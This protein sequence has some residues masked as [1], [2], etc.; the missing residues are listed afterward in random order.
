VTSVSS[1]LQKYKLKHGTDISAEGLADMAN[2]VVALA[3]GDDIAT[4]TE[5]TAH[6]V[7]E[8]FSDRQAIEDVLPDVVS[9][10]EY[11]ANAE[12]YRAIYARQYRDEAQVENLVRREILGK[13][14]AKEYTSRMEA[15][16]RTLLQKIRALINRFIQ[17]LRGTHT[18]QSD[19]L[20][21]VIRQLA[22][23]SLT[24][25]MTRFDSNH[26]LDNDFVMYNAPQAKKDINTAKYLEG[27]D[28]A[29]AM[30]NR[31]KIET[32]AMKAERER[33][34]EKF[35]EGEILN[36]LSMFVTTVDAQATS[37]MQQMK[38]AKQQQ[39]SDP[40]KGWWQ[41][42]S[43]VQLESVRHTLL[44][45]MN[46]LRAEVN[47]DTYGGAAEE[48]ATLLK[49][50]DE[51]VR[52]TNEVASE[53]KRLNRMDSASLI[54]R[55]CE[56]YGVPERSRE[57]IRKHVGDTVKD[58]MAITRWFGALEHSSNPVLG[59]LMNVISEANTK[60][61]IHARTVM[62]PLFK[63]IDEK[64]VGNSQYRQIITRDEKGNPTGYLQ[65]E[66]DFARYSRARRD[67]QLLALQ[68]VVR[69]ENGNLKYEKLSLDELHKLSRRPDFA[70]GALR[71]ASGE[72]NRMSLT[73]DE[74]AAVKTYMDRWDEENNE[75]PYTPE[76]YARQE[77][78]YREMAE[79]REDYIVYD[80]FGNEIYAIRKGEAISVEARRVVKNLSGRRS[81][82]L[83]KYRD[84]NGRVDWSR[85][86]DDAA[87]VAALNQI[88]HD[89]E[90][91]KSEYDVS[92][93]E[94]K[95]GADLRIAKDIQAMDNY[96][97]DAA[98]QMKA[99][100]ALSDVTKMERKG[101]RMHVTLRNG[102]RYTL[103][104]PRRRMREEFFTKVREIQLSQGNQT[105]YDFVRKNG[106]LTFGDAF[107]EQ[108]AG[109]DADG[110][111]RFRRTV[112]D[113]LS[114][115]D[116]FLDSAEMDRIMRMMAR[117][118]EVRRKR[119]EVLRAHR[120]FDNP[121]ETD[122]DSMSTDARDAVRRYTEEL[123]ELREDV[124]AVFGSQEITLE[125]SEF[126]ENEANEAYY[127]AFADDSTVANE[128][129]F[130]DA[131]LT[132]KGQSY[133][134]HFRRQMERKNYL[135]EQREARFI[136]KY[137]S[138]TTYRLKDGTPDTAG[139]LDEYFSAH[140]S[141]D[142]LITEY[143][144]T[145]LLPYFKR[146]APAG[147]DALLRDMR[148]GRV[149]M[150]VMLSELRQP[151]EQRNERY[152]ML[153]LQTQSDWYEDDDR[154]EQY[155]NSDYDW[156]GESGMYQPRLSKYRNEDFFS[157][158]APVKD[159]NG[160]WRASQ[161]RELWDMIE[162]FKGIKR[163]ALANYNEQDR[164]FH[165]LYQL[166][167]ISKTMTQKSLDALSAAG[168]GKGKGA[169]KQMTN[170]LKDLL[171]TR[172]D[173]PLYGQGADLRNVETPGDE[174]LLIMPKYYL[175][176]LEDASD[177]ST[178]LSYAY[179]MLIY[180]SARYSANMDAIGEVHGL[181]QELLDLKFRGKAATDTNMYKMFKD[182]ANYHFY[183]RRMNRKI[184][185]NVLGH[186]VDASKAVHLFTRLTGVA[187]L[188]YSLVIGGTSAAT[189]ASNIALERVV[190]Q[191]V[192][193][194]SFKRALNETRKMAPDFFGEYA[195]RHKKS[196]L[197]VLGE[198]FGLY[199]FTERA[200]NSGYRKG[201]R[202]FF[203]A[204]NPF[205]FMEF[206]NSPFTP[207]VMTSVLMGYRLVDG[208]FMNFNQFER[209]E[210]FAGMS[211]KEISAEWSK[212]KDW[213]LW[214]GIEVNDGLV[215][216]AGR[217]TDP[218]RGGVS[219][220]VMDAAVYRAT[221]EIQVLNEKCDGTIAAED[222][223]TIARNY[224]TS[225]I[226]MHQ[227]WLSQAIARRRKP[228]GYNFSTNQEEEGAY[229]TMIRFFR[230]AFGSVEERNL[231]G[232][233]KALR[234][235]WKNLDKVD[236]Q[237]WKRIYSDAAA[238][239]AF[240]AIAFILKGLS[241]DDDNKDSWIVQLMAYVGLRTVNEMNSQTFE[242]VFFKNVV[243][244]VKSPLVPM[245]Q[246]QELIA[247]KDYFGEVEQGR[248]K[249]HLKL[250]RKITELTFWKNI[251]RILGAESIRKSR[252][253][254]ENMAA[255]YLWIP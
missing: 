179:S 247:L 59:M 186:E 191:Y 28:A 234:A 178:D 43:E 184:A 202:G 175:G 245:R 5:E 11:K 165:N 93:G 107:W 20:R 8:T 123:E 251:D 244:R 42:K 3:N 192:D 137:F 239:A 151:A 18:D 153:E 130:I 235:N 111:D 217:F 241:D 140:D 79:L 117:I 188:G 69:D 170:M 220:E 229:R 70:K 182:W 201:A 13:L 39:A 145:L 48:K 104:L 41:L 116:V 163:Q 27:L 10:D 138:N 227:G 237:N 238:V 125:F 1:Y 216:Y 126:S 50:M 135:F 154:M 197:N 225:G 97:M 46:E 155:R 233:M 183:G 134:R 200:A 98:E 199:S 40:D 32:G 158:F 106:R 190:G 52:R 222:K 30:Q 63:L 77:Q 4:L 249:G 205:S 209:R 212:Y 194:E 62:Q 171:T 196:R 119:T 114:S 221:R 166:P 210:T 102:T 177:V 17:R 49:R 61:T 147:Y 108:M 91:L 103:D 168:K 100:H 236:R 25:E 219:R 96:D 21:E 246:F 2:R 230:E 143:G 133:Y 54:D 36:G 242:P 167:Q 176:E 37:L 228:R 56:R 203:R 60:A 95:Q 231:S 159:A 211:P 122:Y 223:S 214:D 152:G 195:V 53:S 19:R 68:S 81:A 38:R 112:E 232:I 94:R 7:V 109:V 224:L 132:R 139:A 198:H 14:L 74:Y 185:F 174:R 66:R 6:F 57:W 144:K 160:R 148:K 115:E 86:Q 35:V 80:D 83:N 253:G 206:I 120:M 142:K 226:M 161:N 29:Y 252:Q 58:C 207:H 124:I 172:I 146:F 12:T 105:A 55:F 204:L 255:D 24:R 88:A 75:T 215:K 254:W 149:D 129:D 87:A 47:N 89:R 213:S 31:Q 99:R 110:R 250:Y 173:D 72:I 64:N 141:F 67:T 127:A 181:E 26:L 85:L 9:T 92:T 157:L 121:A 187:N 71:T 78:A 45:L 22:D 51:I 150:D 101:A 34:A 243:E 131:H 208:R 128:K 44:P 23:L 189:M 118:D 82:V 113:A 84:G 90:E 193:G 248:Y 33:M 76:Y 218:A 162:M 73:E 156:S 136:E 16:P 169:G 15:T 180:Q 240:T 65:N 164:A